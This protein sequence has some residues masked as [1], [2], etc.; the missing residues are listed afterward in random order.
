MLQTHLVYFLPQFWNQPSAQS[1]EGGE[2]GRYVCVWAW[3]GPARSRPERLP[4][5]P[6][7]ARGGP[8][9]AAVHALFLLLL[10]RLTATFRH[11]EQAQ[12]AN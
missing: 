9:S 2:L 11:Q 12:T 7:V 1:G 5:A 3:S 4:R 10:L 6:T 8:P